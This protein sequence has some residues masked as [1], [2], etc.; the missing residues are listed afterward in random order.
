MRSSTV[1][2]ADI[3]RFEFPEEHCFVLDPG[4]DEDRGGGAVR[5][6]ELRRLRGPHVLRDTGVRGL[7]LEDRTVAERS[8]RRIERAVRHAVAADVRRDEAHE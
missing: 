3:V 1:Q 5:L 7:A 2:Y 4:R 8:Q 6:P